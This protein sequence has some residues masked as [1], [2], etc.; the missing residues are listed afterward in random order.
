MQLFAPDIVTE[1]L[2]PEQEIIF[3]K[4]VHSIA[5]IRVAQRDLAGNLD[6][7]EA[8]GDQTSAQRDLMKLGAEARQLHPACQL[9][10]YVF[11]DVA[12][13][14]SELLLLDYNTCK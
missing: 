1:P 2:S 12:L 4:I 8:Y 10:L 13:A 7:N 9:A 3:G 6:N 11:Q 14:E 5:K